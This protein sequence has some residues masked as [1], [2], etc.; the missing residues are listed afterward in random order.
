MQH[1]MSEFDF[2]FLSYDEP[3][4]ETLYVCPRIP[5]NDVDVAR[6]PG[7]ELVRIGG[8]ADKS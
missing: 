8:S 7:W 4:A 3:N 5:R 2:V 6:S 1:E